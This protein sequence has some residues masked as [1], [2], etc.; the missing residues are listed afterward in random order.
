[1]PAMARIMT[2][3]M[4]KTFASAKG[5]AAKCALGTAVVRRARR[6]APGRRDGRDVGPRSLVIWQPM[7]PVLA[8]MPWN[9]PLWQ[10]MRFAAP[11]LMAGN[12]GLSRS[13]PP[14]CRSTALFI[15]EV[16]RRAGF[17][18]GTFQP[19]HPGRPGGQD[20]RGRPHR[21]GDPD[22]LRGGR[23]V[24]GRAGRWRHQEVRPRARGLDPF[25]VLPSADLDTAVTDGGD[26]PCP[27]H[28]PVLHRGQAVHRPW[29]RL[30]GVRRAFAT[31]WP[32]AGRRPVRTGHRDGPARLGVPA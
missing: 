15:E 3:E 32:R 23:S 10:V 11:A 5:E 28:R 19:A 7:G 29:R 30:R 6:G 26:G 1:M 9:F 14:T 27:E 17:P 16:F 12:I 13:T 8:V 20:D 25:V 22:R 31:A 18:E 21:G 2:T 24:G 4:G